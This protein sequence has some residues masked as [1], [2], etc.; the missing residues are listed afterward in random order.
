MDQPWIASCSTCRATARRADAG[1][2]APAAR[3]WRSP[4]SSSRS[5]CCGSS[6]PRRTTP[7]R[8]SP[9]P[10][11][12]PS[13]SASRRR[14]RS[15]TSSPG[16]VL[17][18]SQPIRLGDRVS[19]RRLRR[20]RRGDRALVLAAAQRRRDVDRVPER[21]AGAEGDREQ[22]AA[23]RRRGRARARRACA[24]GEW[25]RAAAALRERAGEAG[26]REV[27]VIVSR[28]RPRRGHDRAAR[29]L[30][31]GRAGGPR[32]GASC[33]AAAAALTGAEHA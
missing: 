33:A 14:A 29:P 26:L 30:L 15:R 10:R 18:F 25:E 23:R 8:C 20:R 7:A 17:A 1:P 28:R 2:H 22:H 27:D 16:I 19:D 13:S 21:A 12:S 24:A 32:R 5:W 6:R 3:A 4:S 9:R 11:S 31:L